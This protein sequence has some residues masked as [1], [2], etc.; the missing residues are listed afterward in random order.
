[1]Y[2]DV[3][4]AGPAACLFNRALK[5]LNCTN[6]CSTARHYRYQVFIVSWSSSFDVFVQNI[7]CL[8]VVR[9]TFGKDIFYALGCIISYYTDDVWK[10]ML[11]TALLIFLITRLSRLRYSLYSFGKINNRILSLFKVLT[12]MWR[13]LC[14]W[15][16]VTLKILCYSDTIE[17]WQSFC[18][19]ASLTL[20]SQSTRRDSAA[21]STTDRPHDKPRM[22]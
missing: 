2:R 12:T 16:L 8:C 18:Q 9:L 22:R 19:E 1:M 21:T 7:I 3:C 17:D 4:A 14:M 20:C 11:F 13:D 6:F 15:Y 10:A 5:R